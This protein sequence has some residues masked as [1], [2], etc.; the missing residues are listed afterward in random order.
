[1]IKPSFS[2]VVAE[3]ANF[4]RGRPVRAKRSTGY[5]QKKLFSVHFKSGNVSISDGQFYWED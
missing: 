3:S 4:I 1:M 2:V 5:S